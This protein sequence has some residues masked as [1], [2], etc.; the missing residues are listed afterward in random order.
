MEKK[1]I[2][3]DAFNTFKTLEEN[4]KNK[5]DRMKVEDYGQYFVDKANEYA[6]KVYN[7]TE[8][9]KRDGYYIGLVYNIP[10]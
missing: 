5:I 4:V 2:F 7:E 10:K 1:N 9:Y 6:E 8:V 3:E